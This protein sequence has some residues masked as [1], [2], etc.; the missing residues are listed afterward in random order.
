MTPAR[1]SIPS[2]LLHW[3][4]ALAIALAWGG[5]QLAEAL[6]RGP[7]R[8]M[9]FGVHALMGLAVLALLLP[10]LLARL[11]G[12]A[13]RAAP[14]APMWEQRLGAAAHLLLYALMILLPLTGLL[15]ALTGRAPFD[16]AGLATLPNALV[17]TGLRGTVKGAHEVLANVMLGAVALHVV[18][19]L[20]HAFVRRDGVAGRMIPWRTRTA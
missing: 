18:A 17:A 1:Y 15:T 13:P 3:T 20:W 8:T 16:L 6:A 7:S 19:V 5:A 14:R 10:R 11:L 9:V 2:I 12:A 4:M